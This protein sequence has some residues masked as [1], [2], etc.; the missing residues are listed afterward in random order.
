[1][2]ARRLAPIVRCVLIH[3]TYTFHTVPPSLAHTV[4]Q[5]N[6]KRRNTHAS[7]AG[8]TLVE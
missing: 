6:L 7:R 4:A 3:L 5:K 8:K 2:L 1:M